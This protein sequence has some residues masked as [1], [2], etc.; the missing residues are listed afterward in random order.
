MYGSAR[1]SYGAIKEED[2]TDMNKIRQYGVHRL[3]HSLT[4]KEEQLQVLQIADGCYCSSFSLDGEEAFT[5]WI[6]GTAILSYKS[7]MDF[8]LPLSCEELMH[9]LA[10]PRNGNSVYVWHIEDPDWH[11]GMVHHLK[12]L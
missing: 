12:R 4:M 5:E 10:Q 7:E 1:N 8:C 11:S 9:K 6:G 2:K 3:L